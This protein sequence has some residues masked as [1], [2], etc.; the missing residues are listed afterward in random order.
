MSINFMNQKTKFIDV[1]NIVG[2]MP[3]Q[4]D[5]TLAVVAKMKVDNRC[6]RSLLF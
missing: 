2:G 1:N 6:Q 4:M 5:I 3:L